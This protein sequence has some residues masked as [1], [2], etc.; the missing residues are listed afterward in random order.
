MGLTYLSKFGELMRQILENSREVYI[1]LDEE[2]ESL[3]NYLEIQQ[4]RYNNS[5]GYEIII[6]HAINPSELMVPPLIAQPFVEN[7]IE[8]GMIYRIENGKVKI[9]IN[10]D[11]DKIKLSVEDNGVGIKELEVI[12]KN[13]EYTKKSLATRI[14]R[15]RLEAMSRISRQKF[16]F[17]IESIQSGGTLV[18]LDLPII[19]AV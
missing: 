9:K 18:T 1:T 2:I 3:E 4:L 15:E 17:A 5:F 10:T 7:A 12:P 14:T 13:P 8:H 11:T 16:N 6:D 19:S